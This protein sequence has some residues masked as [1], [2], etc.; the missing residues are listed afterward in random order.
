MRPKEVKPKTRPAWPWPNPHDSETKYM[1]PRRDYES[2]FFN[3][4]KRS[5]KDD[6]IARNFVQ[7][8]IVESSWN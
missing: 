3:L 4:R 2:V 8:L 6:T 1:I 7:A 5:T